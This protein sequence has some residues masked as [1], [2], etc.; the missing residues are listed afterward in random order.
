P[1]DKPGGV[2]TDY[3]VLIFDADGNFISAFSGT[4]DNFATQ[5]PIEDIEIDNPGSDAN[6][7]VVIARAGTSP[8][9]PVASKLRY[10]GI[11]DFG[12][13][14]GAS[15]FYQEDAPCT[16]GHNSAAGA[17]GIAAYVY[18]DD[19]SNPPGPPF[20]PVV[21][22]FTSPGPVTIDFDSSGN[23]LAT[24]EIRQK[25]DFAAPDGGNTTFFG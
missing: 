9:T 7:Q 19:P 4:D 22:D 17:C 20:T 23:R 11:D 21:E 5:E 12:G 18:D 6:F 2:T 13:G 25:P 8:A 3:T 15:N 10:I 24:S 16:F 14:V 1:F